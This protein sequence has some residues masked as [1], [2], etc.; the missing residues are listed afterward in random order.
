[1]GAGSGLLPARYSR[2]SFCSI[3]DPTARVYRESGDLVLQLILTRIST[4]SGDL[5]QAVFQLRPPNLPTE[6]IS[7]SGTTARD[8]IHFEDVQ[9]FHPDRAFFGEERH[10]PAVGAGRVDAS[11]QAGAAV[12]E[13]LD[14]GAIEEN[15]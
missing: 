9:G 10:A 12:G 7:G 2:P 15:G 14:D 1:M 3:L 6:C 8:G 5:A 4:S 13:N 11:R